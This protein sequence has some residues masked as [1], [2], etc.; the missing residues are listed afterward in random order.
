MSMRSRTD[1]TIPSDV[2]YSATIGGRREIKYIPFTAISDGS[3]AS[4]ITEGSSET[5]SFTTNLGD[6]SYNFVVTPTAR[7]TTPTGT[8]TV[9]SGAGTFSVE[10]V[11]NAVREADTTGVI[12]ISNIAND[13][14]LVTLSTDLI[15]D[16]PITQ[17]AVGFVEAV[18]R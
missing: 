4:S 11:T 14:L 2:N 17:P 9:S 8:F 5:V 12:R 15:D 1:H 10:A 6:G 16:S 13:T 3:V 7:I 18:E